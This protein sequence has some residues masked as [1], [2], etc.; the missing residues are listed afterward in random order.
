MPITHPETARSQLNLD[1]TFE[2]RAR[3]Y[4]GQPPID[5]QHSDD[6]GRTRWSDAALA[7]LG[8]VAVVFLVVWIAG[9]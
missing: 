8:A 9:A 1:R 2:D 5:N 4:E 7:V 3:R 6:V